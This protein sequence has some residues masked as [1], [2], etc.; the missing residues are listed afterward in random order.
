MCGFHSKGS[1]LVRTLYSMLSRR[2]GP[3]SAVELKQIVW[4][5]FSPLAVA[6][7]GGAA[8]DVSAGRAALEEGRAALTARN[9]EGAAAAFGKACALA[10]SEADSCYYSG[11]TLHILGRFDESQRAFERALEHAPAQAK[12][13]IHRAAALNLVGLG[14]P[15]K[16]EIQFRAAVRSY[17]DRASGPEDPRVDYGAFLVRQGRTEDALRLL[18]N[19][20]KA[21]PGSARAHAELGKALLDSGNAQAA[22]K[23]LERALALDPSAWPTRLILG[24][25]YLQLGRTQEADREFRLGREGWSRRQN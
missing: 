11:Q 8:Q 10:P 23:S 9:M 6:L 22:A 21:K 4:L 20:A 1:Q 25:A 14:Q 7:S 12:A 18:E 2:P 17:L 19:A 24:R 16:A 15:E 5:L 13:R 3:N